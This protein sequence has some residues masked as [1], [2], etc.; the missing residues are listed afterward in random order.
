M[1]DAR[2]CSAIIKER[3]CSNR[4]SFRRT[5]HELHRGGAASHRRWPSAPGAP[6]AGLRGRPPAA[7]TRSMRLP[8]EAAAASALPSAGAGPAPSRQL[9][10]PRLCGDPE[11][12]CALLV[13]ENELKWSWTRPGPGE[14]DFAQVD[15]IADFAEANGLR[16]CAATR[17][18]G[19]IPTGSRPGRRPTTSAP[20]PRA[21]AEA[22]L[23]EHVSTVCRRYG[24]T[25]LFLRRRQRG[26]DSR[27]RRDARD[28]FL[29]G[30]GR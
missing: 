24:D 25:H 1:V 19:T 21:K 9:R 28:R 27:H 11:R 20:S 26:G 8:S 16:R 17:C 5:E 18:S 7:N 6:G 2:L 4:A 3:P 10:Q 13:P 29:A 23:R 14:F 12:K 30:D 15:A 22:M